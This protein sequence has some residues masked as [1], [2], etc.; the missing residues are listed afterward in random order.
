MYKGVYINTRHIN[1]T[2]MDD[3]ITTIE[4]REPQHLVKDIP[5]GYIKEITVGEEL[6]LYG[7]TQQKINGINTNKY[8]HLGSG[9]YK[10]NPPALFKSLHINKNISS[11]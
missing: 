4:Y 5:Y 8:L 6:R 1:L 11:I 9:N 3:T 7:L 2:L 10:I